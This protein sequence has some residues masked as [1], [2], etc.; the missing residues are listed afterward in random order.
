MGQT[1][2]CTD[3]CTPSVPF[4][5]FVTFRCGGGTLIA[6]SKFPV[7][8][9]T[10]Q[11]ANKKK[12]EK[13]S[14]YLD[15]FL[16]RLTGQGTEF[17]FFVKLEIERKKKTCPTTLSAAFTHGSPHPGFVEANHWLQ[18]VW[19]FF[20]WS[21]TF[22]LKLQLRKHSTV[23]DCDITALLSAYTLLLH[24]NSLYAYYWFSEVLDLTTSCEVISVYSTYHLSI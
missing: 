5:L 19:W 1:Q 8:V 6:F 4:S 11:K 16:L 2:T 18:T 23:L 9:R 10:K 20:S 24:P 12:K 21:K 15:T 14:T 17:H 13:R 3:T 22:Y 7:I